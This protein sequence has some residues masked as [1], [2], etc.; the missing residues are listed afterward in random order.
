MKKPEEVEVP[1][2]PR[3]AERAAW[4]DQIGRDSGD[5]YG[6]GNKKVA[7][8]LRANS[9][10]PHETVKKI[11][12]DHMAIVVADISGGGEGV[13]DSEKREKIIAELQAAREKLKL[14]PLTEAGL[15]ALT[16][17]PKLDKE[18]AATMEKVAEKQQENFIKDAN[19]PTFKPL[20]E[21]Q[22]KNRNTLMNQYRRI[23]HHVD[24][25]A[26]HMTEE[27]TLAAQEG[28]KQVYEGLLPMTQPRMDEKT[29]EVIPSGKVVEE[30]FQADMDNWSKIENGRKK[31]YEEKQEAR[32]DIEQ[33]F[34][35]EKH[36]EEPRQEHEV[37]QNRLRVKWGE[38]RPETEFV[39]APYKSTY[40]PE[41]Y[42][43]DYVFT[44]YGSSDHIKEENQKATAIYDKHQQWANYLQGGEVPEEVQHRNRG[45][46]LFV[47]RYGGFLDQPGTP[48]SHEFMG[49]GRAT[50]PSRGFAGYEKGELIKSNV[51][52]HGAVEIRGGGTYMIINFQ[53]LRLVMEELSQNSAIWYRLQKFSVYPIR[54]LLSL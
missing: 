23:N 38:D 42:K 35:K 7:D 54:M 5:N 13:Y 6:F 52:T 45:S 8:M 9:A 48:V 36:D 31:E 40:V 2:D 34:L 51:D 4:I 29:E 19:I 15:T 28:F 22:A 20:D 14:Q 1:E 47:T 50:I 46:N 26:D 44:D 12:T 32:H 17:G 41:E 11:F 49:V 39:P 24:K 25:Y 27:T 53:I 43:S 30:D 18:H 10:I 3:A 16:T 21:A 33:N 37:E